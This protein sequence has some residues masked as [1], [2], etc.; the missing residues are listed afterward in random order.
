MLLGGAG[1]DAEHVADHLCARTRPTVACPARC[2]Q[3]DRHRIDWRDWRYGTPDAAPPSVPRA[4][5]GVT[6]P[7]E[8]A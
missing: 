5:A 3:P 2:P 4:G 8:H 6:N 7:D 1:R